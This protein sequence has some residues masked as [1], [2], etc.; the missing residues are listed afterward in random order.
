M[1]EFAVMFCKGGIPSLNKDI[2]CHISALNKNFCSACF[3]YH[4]LIL[5]SLGC[6]L[7]EQDTLADHTGCKIHQCNQCSAFFG[8]LS[9]AEWSNFWCSFADDGILGMHLYNSH[10][11]W[12]VLV[13][14]VSWTYFCIDNTLNDFILMAQYGNM[15][16]NWI[17]DSFD[18]GEWKTST[19]SKIDS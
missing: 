19:Y 4:T 18:N 9:F 2:Q 5:I 17:H 10:P 12:C 15:W 7:R 16:C 1:L 14:G 3:D 6:L 8:C 13:H 11:T